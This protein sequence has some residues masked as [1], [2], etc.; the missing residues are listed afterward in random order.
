MADSLD[1]GTLSGRIELEDRMSNILTLTEKAL[2][3][4]D[5]E[6]RKTAQGSESL[7]AGVFKGELALD[8]LK[9]AGELAADGLKAVYNSM[10]EGSKVL[11]VEDTFN[12]MSSAAGILGDTLVKDVQAAMKGTIDDTD[13]M[14]RMNANMAAG[15]T[16]TSEQSMILAKGSWALAKAMGVDAKEAMDKLS[17]AMVTG[18]TRSIAMLTGK[19]D[20]TDA[21]EKFAKRLGTTVEHLTAE[22]KIQAQREIILSKVAEATERIG[23]TTVRFGDKVKAAQILWAEF[24]ERVSTGMADSPVFAAMV[25]S[26][27]EAF[28]K[29]FDEN[30]AS[31]VETIVH[32]VEDVAIGLMSAGEVA[33]DVVGVLGFLFYKGKEGFD[34]LMLGVYELESQLAETAL[35]AYKLGDALMMPGAAAGVMEMTQHLKD[36]QGEQAK[37]ADAAD[38]NSKAADE[39]AVATGRFKEALSG[40]RT[41][42]EEA[43]KSAGEHKTATKEATAATEAGTVAA[44]G[45]AAA[46]ENVAYTMEKTREEVKQY[47]AAMKEL[48]SITTDFHETVRALNPEMVAS[49][50]TYLDAGASQSTLA[51]VY[52]LTASQMAAVNKERQEEI[53]ALKIEEDAIS[54]LNQMWIAFNADKAMLYATDTEKSRLAAEAN[55]QH[56][57]ES[58]RRRHVVD[59]E[60][61]DSLARLRDES[62]KLDEQAR[63]L[64]DERTLSALEARIAEARDMYQFMLRHGRDYT[65]ATIDQQYE[66][67]M[68]LE[69]Q[70]E[71]WG[72][73]GEQIATDT[74]QV[75]T[76]SAAVQGL[77]GHMSA[78]YQATV[79]DVEARNTPVS[80][81]SWAV[82]KDTF[83]ASM[84]AAH[85]KMSMDVAE[86]LAM[87]GYSYGE[88]L[89]YRAI[90][91]KMD[92]VVGAGNVKK[93]ILQM[94]EMGTFPAPQGPRIPGFKEGGVGDFGTGTLVM[95][96]G[97]EA[98][99]P[100]D[101]DT[102]GNG[103]TGGNVVVHNYIN[104][105]AADVA[106][107]V[108]AEL[109]RTLQATRQFSFGS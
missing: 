57:V 109:M 92:F 23:E 69:K 41:K 94:V 80:G 33:T 83:R 74:G 47:E 34:T 59:V 2:A 61:Y 20:L 79:A 45:H 82:T 21:E 54:S 40:V 46:Q 72:R 67:W 6:Q 48:A 32:L 63:L 18:R 77:A 85:I 90:A 5:D 106:R 4:F 65:N 29:A 52:G 28:N 68:A 27:G 3:K 38:K 51:T 42:M 98:I 9:K 11:D 100:L 25:D 78:L 37:W 15:L 104:G 49:I 75:Q 50:K 22:G 70:R 12:R 91:E 97:K 81:G 87:A 88:I 62:I 14:I 96:H 93:K 56:A 43:Q 102:G 31:G 58:A 99:V 105:T 86:G 107:Q 26:F 35:M 44:E 30:Q 101:K 71:Q 55:Y 89:G 103:G 73:I 84:E 39:W 36:V 7:A 64:A 108:S 17:D 16:L 1:I 76:M 19:V 24:W 53:R 13:V 95:L 8:A 60:Y 10:M 66:V